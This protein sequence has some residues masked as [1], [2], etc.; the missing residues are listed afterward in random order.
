MKICEDCGKEYQDY[1]ELCPYC[2]SEKYKVKIN[3]HQKKKPVV[4][5][6]LIDKDS[7]SYNAGYNIGFN[8]DLYQKIIN[9]DDVENVKDENFKQGYRDGFSERFVFGI[10]AT[11]IIAIAFVVYHVIIT[12]V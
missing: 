3:P 11:I 5:R 9:K 8:S 2:A 10:V 1:Q 6:T 4:K 7:K 12:Y